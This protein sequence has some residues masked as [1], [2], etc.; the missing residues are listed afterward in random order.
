LKK[1]CLEAVPVVVGG[2]VPEADERKLKRAGV[3]EIFHPGA[4]REEIV[5]KV[6]ALAREARTAKSKE[7]LA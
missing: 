1:A 2:I 4:S 6:A 7:L 5:S 3:R